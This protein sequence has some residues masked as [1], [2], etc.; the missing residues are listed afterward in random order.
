[1]PGRALTARADGLSA[2]PAESNRR[3][4]ERMGDLVEQRAHFSVTAK[5][6]LGVE[7]RDGCALEIGW[8]AQR[9]LA[10]R[11]KRLDDVRVE[12]AH[13]VAHDV[14]QVALVVRVI[15]RITPSVKVVHGRTR[16]WLRI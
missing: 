14:D 5:R 15:Q 16:V 7:D 11:R 2:Q 4:G 10:F 1:M 13:V 12:C 3:G 6:K 9:R 8:V